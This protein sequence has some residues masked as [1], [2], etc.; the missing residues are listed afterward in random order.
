MSTTFYGDHRTAALNRVPYGSFALPER[1]PTEAARVVS[2]SW[3]ELKNIETLS[4]L[5]DYQLDDI[6]LSHTQICSLARR[7][8]EEPR[9]E[10]RSFN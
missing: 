3:D 2:I 10:H 8:A 6:G 5:D 9:G 1:T 4:G 7:S